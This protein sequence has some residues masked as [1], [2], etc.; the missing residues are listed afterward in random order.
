M[1]RRISIAL[2]LDY[3]I[4]KSKFCLVLFQPLRRVMMKRFSKPVSH[5]PPPGWISRPSAPLKPRAASPGIGPSRVTL[6]SFP[7][8]RDPTG[9]PGGNASR[10][11]SP[12]WLSGFLIIRTYPGVDRCGLR[13]WI[14]GS[15]RASLYSP[16]SETWPR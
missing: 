14:T 8:P 10:I 3:F 2:P 13:A 9:M 12:M 15:G 6:K 1:I 11:P 5:R 4:L 16:S 7:V